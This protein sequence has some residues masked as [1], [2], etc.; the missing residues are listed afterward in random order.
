MNA[1]AGLPCFYCNK[2]VIPCEECNGRGYDEDRTLC[3]ECLA[4]GV[5]RCD[6]CGGSGWFTIDHVPHAFK[7]NVIMRRVLTAGKEAEVVLASDIAVVSS[8]EPAVTRKLAAKELLQVNRLLGVLENMAVAAKQ[9]ASSYAESAEVTHKAT[10]ACEALAPKLQERTC[11]L[12]VTLADAAKAE[13]ASA[14]R[15]ETRRLSERRAEFYGGLASS[16]NFSGTLL[17]H[18]LIF[19]EDTSATTSAAPDDEAG[20]RSNAQ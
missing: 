17:R 11:Q 4:L 18:P 13:A 15:T 14:T 6:F 1:Y 5:N 7:L 16:K 9:E 19:D 8:A 20:G 2:G 3:A 10:A 12:L